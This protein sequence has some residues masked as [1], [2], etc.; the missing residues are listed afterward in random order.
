M[1]LSAVGPLVQP[2][3]HK[4][5]GSVGVASRCGVCFFVCWLFDEWGNKIPDV[6]VHSKRFLK[7]FA[8]SLLDPSPTVRGAAIEAFSVV[9][10]FATPQAMQEVMLLRT[11]SGPPIPFPVDGTVFLPA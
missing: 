6:A 3:V 2:L 11:H 8:R 9:C 7:A 10:K 1:D 4:L 5:R